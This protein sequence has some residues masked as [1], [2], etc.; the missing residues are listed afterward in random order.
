MKHILLRGVTTRA[1]ELLGPG[2]AS[3]GPRGKTSFLPDTEQKVHYTSQEQFLVGQSP[4]CE[5]MMHPVPHQDVG[6]SQH[7]PTKRNT[8]KTGLLR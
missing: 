6:M 7:G 1:T 2:S 5:P 4:Q 3:L 8:S